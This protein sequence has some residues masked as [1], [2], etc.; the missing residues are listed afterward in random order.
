MDER[1]FPHG[2]LP[3]APPSRRGF[4]IAGGLAV[5]SAGAGAWWARRDDGAAA[6]QRPADTQELAAA[7]DA[8]RELIALIDALARHAHGER[9]ATLSAIGKDHAAHHAAIRAAIADA[10]YPRPL[11]AQRAKPYTGPK[12]KVADLLAKERQ[13]ARDAAARAQRLSGRSAALLASIA[14]SEAVHAEVLR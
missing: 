6:P 13:A 7:A 11:P 8:E 3:Q 2:P 12:P 1:P 10:T 4:V 9:A 5:V 14:A